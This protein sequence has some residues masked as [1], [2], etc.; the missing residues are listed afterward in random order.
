MQPLWRIAHA[1]GV[2]L[3]LAGH[4]HSYQRFRRLDASGRPDPRHGVHQVVAGTGGR[5]LYQLAPA[6]HRVAADASGFGVVELALGPRGYSLRFVPV[7]GGTY[8]D[9]FRWAT[10][11]GAPPRR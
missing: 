4:E 6:R 10:C 3:V 2:D 8:T 9:R 7:A 5:S 1:R 11:H